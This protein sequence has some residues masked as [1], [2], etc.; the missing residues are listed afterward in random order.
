MNDE[1]LAAQSE[2]ERLCRRVREAPDENALIG[3]LDAL[4]EYLSKERA[5]LESQRLPVSRG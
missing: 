3:A 4:T 1:F 2:I 5:K